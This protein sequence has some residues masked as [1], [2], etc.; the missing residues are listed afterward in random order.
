M[1]SST[2]QV[3]DYIV[4]IYLLHYCI[5]IIKH[6]S[7]DDYIIFTTEFILTVLVPVLLLVVLQIYTIHT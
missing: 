4:D 7:H 1:F 3:F 2:V 6:Y 5:Q